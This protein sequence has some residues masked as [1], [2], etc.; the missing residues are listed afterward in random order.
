MVKKVGNKVVVIG[1]GSVGI[2]YAFSML[3]Q[4][5][6]DELVLIDLNEKNLEPYVYVLHHIDDLSAKFGK[7]SVSEL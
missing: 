5:N 4:G 6:C 2:S 3:N 1:T 7:T